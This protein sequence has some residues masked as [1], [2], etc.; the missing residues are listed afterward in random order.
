M[1]WMNEKGAIGDVA[2]QALKV[3]T[4]FDD[5]SLL[6]STQADCIAHPM[7][8]QIVFMDILARLKPLLV[9]NGE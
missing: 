4:N 1:S 7:V 8:K 2:C 6:L 9:S 5:Q 3:L